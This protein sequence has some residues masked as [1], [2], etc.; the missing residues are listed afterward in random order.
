[1]IKKCHKQIIDPRRK[2]TV[3]LTA[4]HTELTYLLVMRVGGKLHGAGKQKGQPEEK[5]FVTF[6]HFYSR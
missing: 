1:M 5:C 6:Y 4:L 3:E 2:I